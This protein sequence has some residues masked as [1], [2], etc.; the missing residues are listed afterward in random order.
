MALGAANWLVFLGGRAVGADA[1]E[2]HGGRFVV[3]ILRHQLVFKGALQNGL[4]Q[5]IAL[6]RL[7]FNFRQCDFSCN[8]YPRLCPSSWNERV[9]K[10][11]FRAFRKELILRTRMGRFGNLIDP[12]GF[13]NLLWGS[14][15]LKFGML[16]KEADRKLFSALDH[17]SV[18]GLYRGGLF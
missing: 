11:S 12:A 10:A 8:P 6:R 13:A 17:A 18:V 15:P 1:V 5:P 3:G 16:V 9:R 4:A 2:Q 14:V 7:Y